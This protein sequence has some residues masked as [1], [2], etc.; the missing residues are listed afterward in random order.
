MARTL[1]K[2][3]RARRYLQASMEAGYTGLPAAHRQAKEDLMRGH[4]RAY[5]GVRRHA[6]AGSRR[7]FD[8]PLEPG[9]RAHQR[10]LRE[11]EGLEEPHIQAMQ[12]ELDKSEASRPAAPSGGSGVRGAAGAAAGAAG[13]AISEVTGGGNT[14]LYFIGGALLLSLAYLLL[15]GGESGAG[16]LISGV[17]NVVT[18]AVRT[19]VAPVDPIA[20]AERALGAAPIASAAVP[21]PSTKAGA[22][23]TN[24][25]SGYIDPFS[26]DKTVTAGRIDQGQD[27]ALAPGEA[28]RAI[29]PGKVTAIE[30]N[31]YQGQP[32]VAY[33]LTGGPPRDTPSTSPSRSA[34]ASSSARASRPAR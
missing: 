28:I 19:F 18:G 7:H 16:K 29:G 2:G 4:E 5:A 10:H 20:A 25:Y 33:T 15:K 26:G 27:F 12:R 14:L 21:D 9:E 11:Q 32:L 34:P 13:G 6:L 22:E 8:K 23:A 30:R 17:T 3:A 1:S 24:P 31:W